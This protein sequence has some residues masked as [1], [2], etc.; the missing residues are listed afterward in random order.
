[1]IGTEQ[2]EALERIDAGDVWFDPRFYG[3]CG[4]SSYV[5][6]DLEARG[7]V[8]IDWAHDRG[9]HPRYPR[10]PVVLTAIGGAT[11]AVRPRGGAAA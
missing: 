3:F 5:V 11:I 6:R 4:A 1:M 2:R 8:A 10:H 9:C 7:L